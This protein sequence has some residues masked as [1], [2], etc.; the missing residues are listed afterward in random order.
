MDPENIAALIIDFKEG[1]QYIF[2]K[3]SMI[4]QLRR[5]C[6]KV[7]ASFDTIFENEFKELS[8]TFSAVMPQ[9]LHGLKSS[10]DQKDEMIATCGFML[11]NAGNT[12]MAA[13]QNLRNGFRL[14]SGFLIRS[15]IEICATAI[16]FLLDDEA[17]A[18]FEKDD[19]KSTDAISAVGKALPFFGSIWGALSNKLMHVN[20]T[21]AEIYPLHSY[22]EK[23]DV[24]ATI[25]LGMIGIGMWIWEITTELAFINYLSN[26]SS[27]EKLG[28]NQYKFIMPSEEYMAWIKQT[29]NRR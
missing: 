20:S 4:N 26:V 23:T 22:T 29:L 24:P 21:H 13:V 10:Q 8:A 6:E 7:N 27:W 15:V 11:I 17:F 12:L 3:D 18:K 2:T 9:I 5:E 1:K 19:Y 25:T 16:H 28:P 14:Q